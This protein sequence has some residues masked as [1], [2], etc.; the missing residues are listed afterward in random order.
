MNDIACYL[1]YPGGFIIEGA[2]RWSRSWHSSALPTLVSHA[3]ATEPHT[4]KQR[5]CALLEKTNADFSPST[6]DSLRSFLKAR[7]GRGWICAFAR[8]L[9]DF[10]ET[11]RC[12]LYCL[13]C[14]CGSG[15]PYGS[16]GRPG[17]GQDALPMCSRQGCSFCP[18]MN[19]LTPHLLYHSARRDRKE[20]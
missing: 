9:P 4:C 11:P 7:P 8:F 1:H 19:S 17:V 20:D 2:N 13:H 12:I 10:L 6:C 3:P 14:T 15:S 18:C 16:Q 5:R